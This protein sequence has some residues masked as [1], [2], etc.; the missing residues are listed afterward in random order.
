[1]WMKLE[2]QKCRGQ[3][4]MF[5]EYSALDNQIY[6]SSQGRSRVFGHLYF[7]LITFTG[8]VIKWKKN[9]GIRID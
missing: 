9:K 7:R 3:K 5:L 1:M 2:Y 6:W 8:K 4:Y